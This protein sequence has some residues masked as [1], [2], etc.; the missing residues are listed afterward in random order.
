M[1]MTTSLD[2]VSSVIWGVAG[3]VVG[4]IFLFF[5]VKIFRT[6][7]GLAGFGAFG[8]GAYIFV[9]QIY[10]AAE[11]ARTS[12]NE[13]IRYGVSLAAGAFG[14]FVAI[15]LWKV[16]LVSLGALG[17]LALAIY[18]LSWKSNGLVSKPSHRTI[19]LSSFGVVGVVAA[20]FLEK[21]VII[22]ATSLIGAIGVSFGI[23]VFA[24]T[25]FNKAIAALIANKGN[26]EINA[27][28]YGLL[29]SC[30]ILA[31]AGALVQFY[32]SRRKGKSL[33]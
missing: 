6:A 11:I 27:S 4:S 32:T 26:F 1:N 29:A 8:L 20:M 24:E 12:T 33:E 19:V 31:T 21:S 30:G 13:L 14:G 28:S 16:A 7:V 17:G 3:I 15:W 18:I 10:M 5:G 25:G 2:M 9:G 23:D 22:L